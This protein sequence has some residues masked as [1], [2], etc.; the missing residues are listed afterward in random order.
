MVRAVAERLA[1][2]HGGNA[3]LNLLEAE[4]LLHAAFACANECNRALPAPADTLAPE[5]FC[6]A[7]NQTFVCCHSGTLCENNP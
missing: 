6:I 3:V 5:E 1:S 4:H 2:F 7:D